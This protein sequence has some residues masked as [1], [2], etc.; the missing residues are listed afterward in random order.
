M[1]NYKI[2][3]FVMKRRWKFAN[4]NIRH[5]KSNSFRGLSINL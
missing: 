3:D 2:N 4:Y 1:K 5:I